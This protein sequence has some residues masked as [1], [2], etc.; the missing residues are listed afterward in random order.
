M[1]KSGL[2][3]ENKIARQE[4]RLIMTCFVV[5]VIMLAALLHKLF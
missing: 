1:K 2:E 3:K 4:R 5:G